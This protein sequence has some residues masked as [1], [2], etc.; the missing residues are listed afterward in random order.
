MTGSDADIAKLIDQLI[1]DVERSDSRP[2]VEEIVQRLNQIRA[3]LIGPRT[4]DDTDTPF[5]A[6]F[7]PGQPVTA[8]HPRLRTAVQPI[9]PI[10]IDDHSDDEPPSETLGEA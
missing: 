7:Q 9:D 8:T 1:A 2:S 10:A 5:V 4:A 6:P 3:V